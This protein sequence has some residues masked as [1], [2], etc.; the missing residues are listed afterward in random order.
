M[1]LDPQNILNFWF[2]DIGRDK[3]FALDAKLDVTIR[4]Q[5][6]SIYE[7]AARGDLKKWEET[8]EGMLA[9]LLLLDIFPRRMFRGTARAYAMDE[10]ALDLARTAIIKH[11]DDRIDRAFKLFFY[12]PFQHSE[13]IGDQRLAVF[14]IR[15]RTKEPIWVD[16]AEWR[17]QTIQRFGR[18]PHRNERL[19]RQTTPEEISF[20]AQRDGEMRNVAS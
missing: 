2:V 1:L 10:K 13:H 5:F 16:A 20:L 15:E 12:V 8:P 11:F 17:L 14:Y 18:F 19:G 4:E 6:G 3:W 9:L 7:Q